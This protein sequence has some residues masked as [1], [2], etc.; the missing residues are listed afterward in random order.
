MV[1]KGNICNNC[2][3]KDFFKNINQPVQFKNSRS[4][5]YVKEKIINEGNYLKKAN[6]LCIKLFSMVVFIILKN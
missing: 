3:N 5:A 2:Y 4:K 6:N 1:E